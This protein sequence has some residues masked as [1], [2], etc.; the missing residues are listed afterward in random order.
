MEMLHEN[1]DV[2]KAV[3]Y[4]PNITANLVFT[5]LYTLLTHATQFWWTCKQFQIHL[6]PHLG[7]REKIHI[8]T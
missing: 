6:Y 5:S 4:I 7:E 1:F 3:S 2:N 8:Y